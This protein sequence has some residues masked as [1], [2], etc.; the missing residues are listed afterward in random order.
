MRAAMF[1]LVAGLA[2]PFANT[3][4]G[5]PPAE[6]KFTGVT[7]AAASVDVRAQVTGHLTRVA[8]R[9]GEPVAKGDL[10]A[11]IDAQ[12]YRLALDEAQARLKVAEAKLQAVKI[13]AAS[14]KKLSED[15]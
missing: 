1:V 15:K 11:E 14:A 4:A 2:F 9:E 8:V 12:P 13:K 6:W 3:R 10:L 5:D 7:Q